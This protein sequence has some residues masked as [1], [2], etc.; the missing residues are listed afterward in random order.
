[1]PLDSAVQIRILAPLP[2]TL[3][4]RIVQPGKSATP[5]SKMRCFDPVGQLAEESDGF[6]GGCQAG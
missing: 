6:R 2:E 4:G 5:S 3:A 1:M